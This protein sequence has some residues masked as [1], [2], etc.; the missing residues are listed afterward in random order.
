MG[1]AS[2]E[3][4]TPR[5]VRLSRPGLLGWRLRRR[6]RF[7][8][9]HVSVPPGARVL[10]VGGG[11]GV[12]GAMLLAAGAG[13]VTVV[14]ASER[15]YRDGI[16]LH[17]DPRLHF[18]HGDVFSQLPQLAGVDVVSA[19]HCLQQL[20]PAVH[21]LFAAIEASPVKTVI[22]QGS[23][24]H[25]VQVRPEHEG[26]L[27]GPLVGVPRGMVALLHRYGFQTRLHPHR[28]YPVAAGFR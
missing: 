20:G 9:R 28:R 18:V 8:L 2:F 5:A 21:E 6:Y 11:H 1:A 15:R 19:L 3:G 13:E 23:T 14:E 26:E 4:I 22:L 24:S 25:E 17:R 27:W 7:L 16:R 12:F 10:D